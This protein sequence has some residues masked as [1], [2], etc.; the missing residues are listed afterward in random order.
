MSFNAASFEVIGNYANKSI[1]S[2]WTADNIASLPI[3]TA[4]SGYFNAARFY[5]PVR[6]GD[7]I[8][9][10]NSSTPVI[11]FFVVS[12]IVEGSMIN[13]NVITVIPSIGDQTGISY[14]KSFQFNDYDVLMIDTAFDGAASPEVATLLTSTNKVVIRNFDPTIDEDVLFAWPVPSDMSGSTINYRVITFV[15]NGTG[16]VNEGVAFFLQGA[17]IGDGDNLAS[18]LGAAVL[19]GWTGK[20]ELQYDRVSTEWSGP[21][22]LTG[23]IPG[24]TAL[25]K[26][27]RDIS[28]ASDDY[29]QDIGMAYL[30]IKYQRTVMR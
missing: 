1:W 26:L 22:T 29:A 3:G 7:I 16:P 19:S 11:S 25:L 17:A 15:S 8:M 13:Q 14:A 12:G 23:L 30:E 21:V 2:Y 27:Y 24:K 4:V 20:T 28:D 9:S 6:Q 10:V 5:Y 18:A